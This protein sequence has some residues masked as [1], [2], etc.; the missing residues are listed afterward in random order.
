MRAERTRTAER[1]SRERTRAAERESA[2]RARVTQAAME[3]R[4]GAR[5]EEFLFCALEH[6]TGRTQHRSVGIAIVEGY[7]QQVPQ[8]LDVIV[9]VLIN[10]LVYLTTVAEPSRTTTHELQN[11]ERLIDL[12]TAMAKRTDITGSFRSSYVAMQKARRSRLRLD[13]SSRPD[14]GIKLDRFIAAGL[15]LPPAP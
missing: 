14:L 3:E 4:E 13:L 10:Q 9:P 15:D 1:E 6:F 11:L 7:W 8:L 2:E 5:R 12:L